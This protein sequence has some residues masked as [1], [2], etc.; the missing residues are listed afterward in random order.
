MWRLMDIRNLK[1]FLNNFNKQRK[2]LFT[3]YLI[4]LSRNFGNVGGLMFPRVPYP[5]VRL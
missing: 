3:N 5:Y 1:M 4:C 2:N